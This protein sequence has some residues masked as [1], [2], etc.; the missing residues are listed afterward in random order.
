MI[1]F[2]SGGARSGKSARAEALARRWHQARG[3]ER[4]YL[5]TARP[6]DGEMVGR[7]ARHREARGPGWTTLEE[8]VDLVAALDRVAP[9][10]TLLLDCLTL[11]ASQ[12][13]YASD[14]DE[15]QALT[16]LDTMLSWA[17]ARNIALVVVSNDLN[18]EVPPRDAEVKRYVAFL[19]RAHRRVVHEAELAI[20]V[21]AGL[22]MYWKGNEW[23]GKA[24]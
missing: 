20:Q 8:P 12:V 2:V 9:G 6:T 11:W 4:Y 23:T 13:L 22:P 18:E 5:A 21:V 3:G 14:L 19:Q 10:S 16:M 1:A 24:Q 15:R 17:R 7:I